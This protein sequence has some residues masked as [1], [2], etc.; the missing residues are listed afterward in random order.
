MEIERKIDSLN[1]EVWS[2]TFISY[3]LFFNSY[4]RLQKESTRHRKFYALDRYERI[5]KRRSTIQENEVPFPKEI[6]DKALQAFFKTISCKLW[7]EK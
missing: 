3:T 5:D 1:K 4:Q 7:S 6:R 2:F